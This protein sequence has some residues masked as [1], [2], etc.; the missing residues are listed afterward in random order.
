[1]PEI[2]RYFWTFKREFLFT[3]QNTAED[4]TRGQEN[5]SFDVAVIFNYIFDVAKQTLYFLLERD[6]V[7]APVRSA[8]NYVRVTGTA[9]D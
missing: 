2:P 1:M 7:K 4:D 8:P 3:I 6:K 5:H 9:S